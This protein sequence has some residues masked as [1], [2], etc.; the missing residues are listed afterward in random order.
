MVVTGR[1]PAGSA[2]WPRRLAAR[3]RWW[4]CF[5]LRVAGFQGGG[6]QYRP[7]LVDLQ[8]TA[9]DELAE[10]E[11]RPIQGGVASAGLGGGDRRP[12]PRQRRPPIAA[13]TVGRG[14]SWGEG[15]PAPSPVGL[16]AAAARPGRRAASPSGAGPS[17]SGGRWHAGRVG[18]RPA[19]PG[20][21][22]PPRQEPN[23]VAQP[24]EAIEHMP[25]SPTGTRHR[26]RML[27][28]GDGQDGA[29]RLHAQVAVQVET[30]KRRPVTRPRLAS[31]QH[32]HHSPTTAGSV[33]ASRAAAALAADGMAHG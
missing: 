28:R 10:V 19:H 25:A 2:A 4:P 23:Q 22:S 3:T 26:P 8:E 20:P 24:R 1:R 32:R 12:V 21:A 6:E 33:D 5:C 15:G 30:P 27:N 18:P 11:R 29:K 16:A 14:D 31:G 9:G 13:A 17:G 7:N